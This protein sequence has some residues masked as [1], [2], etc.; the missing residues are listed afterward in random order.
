MGTHTITA[1]DASITWT[2]PGASRPVMGSGTPG[3]QL[4][5]QRQNPADTSVWLPVCVIPVGD[6]S[7]IYE[8]TA[9]SYRAFARAKTPGSAEDPISLKVF[10]DNA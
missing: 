10:V 2:G 8:R 5:V 6:S 7:W 3:T 1:I 4:E 9:G